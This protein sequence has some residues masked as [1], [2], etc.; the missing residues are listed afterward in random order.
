MPSGML[1]RGCRTLQRRVIN[2]SATQRQSDSK[3][4]TSIRSFAVCVDCA[5]VQRDDPPNNRESKTQSAI[6]WP[7]AAVFLPKPIENEGQEGRIDAPSVVGNGTFNLFAA[8][9][10]PE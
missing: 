1:L 6:S 4:R 3:H 7:G 10:N 2:V 5:P 8:P 9:Q